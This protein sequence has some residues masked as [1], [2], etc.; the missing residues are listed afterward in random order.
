MQYNSKFYSLLIMAS[1]TA[2]TLIGQMPT[3][4]DPGAN[5]QGVDVGD[6]STYVI[7]VVGFIVLVIVFFVL[8]RNNK[9][10]KGVR[11]TDRKSN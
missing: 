6:N 7:I 3:H 8:L 9:K 1:L 11:N 10:R 2:A 5:D 4:I